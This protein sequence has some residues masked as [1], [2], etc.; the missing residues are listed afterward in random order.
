M[1]INTRINFLNMLFF[2]FLLFFPFNYTDDSQELCDVPK[3]QKG[4]AIHYNIVL[5]LSNTAF[6]RFL[7]TDIRNCFFFYI[8]LDTFC[9]NKVQAKR[10]SVEER[11]K[12]LEIYDKLLLRLIYELGFNHQEA[13]FVSFCYVCCVFIEEFKRC[14]TISF[15]KIFETNFGYMHLVLNDIGHQLKAFYSDGIAYEEDFAALK[16]VAMRFKLLLRRY[17]QKLMLRVN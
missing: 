6:E 1:V 12:A 4:F 13:S 15:C 14:L 3:R 11:K 2:S 17:F 10:I 5:L 16:M 7:E 8:L 9:V